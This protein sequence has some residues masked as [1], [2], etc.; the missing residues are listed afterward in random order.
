MKF[1]ETE[2]NFIQ[3]GHACN[4]IF[5]LLILKTSKSFST[6]QVQ[7]QN[8]LCKTKGKIIENFK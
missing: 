8:T 6:K 1:K 2:S 5:P 4:Q 7:I 3:F